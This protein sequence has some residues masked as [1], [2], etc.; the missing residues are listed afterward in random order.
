MIPGRWTPLAV[1]ALCGALTAGCKGDSKDTSPADADTD[2]DTDTDSDTD[3]DTDSDSDTDSDTAPPRPC[4]DLTFELAQELD[5]EALVG[6]GPFG[7]LP[8]E[9]GP[10]LAVGDLDGD[11]WLDGVV[12]VRG[13]GT[14]FLRND[15]TGTWVVEP[16]VTLD[17]GAFPESS[18]V[19]LADID[20]DG[21]LDGA[22]GTPV[23]SPDIVFVNQHAQGSSWTFTKKE[24]PNSSVEHL[25]PTF[26]DANGDGRLDIF[27]GSYTHW[28][29]PPGG[30]GDGVGLYFQD[31]NGDFTDETS[32]I[33]FDDQWGLTF[34]GAWMDY[35]NDNDLDLFLVNDCHNAA[36]CAVSNL[37]L[38]NDGSGNFTRVE[39]CYCD[40]PIAG[41][42]V[43][44]GDPN[45]DGAPDMVVTNWGPPEYYINAKDGTFIKGTAAYNVVIEDPETEVTW[46]ALFTDLDLDGDVDL[47][48]NAGPPDLTPEQHPNISETQADPLLINDGTGTFDDMTAEIGI[49]ERGIGR[50]WVRG[51]LDRDNKPELIAVG[52]IF[53]RVYEM[54]GGCEEGITLTLDGGT[55]FAHGIGSHVAVEAG[56]VSQSMWMLPANTCSSSAL[57]LYIGLGEASKADLE[58]TWIDGSTSTVE[59]VAAG[60]ALTVTKD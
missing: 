45:L 16:L 60:T 37:L 1:V 3:T 14:V 54:T 29:P 36:D 5:E 41:M 47:A 24:L 6:K 59:D 25:T 39:D 52:H 30:L 21:D 31:S 55:D 49:E 4:T 8:E 46:G 51:D 38:A 34:L 32:R 56:G 2:T 17:G 35:D 43:G 23:G 33:P 42:G 7:D 53:V 10:G 15:G 27:M 22:I 58:I 50:A 57:E 28:F 19:A 48:I 12:S 44:I 26:A 40:D 13:A 18:A 9:H 11:G 20:G